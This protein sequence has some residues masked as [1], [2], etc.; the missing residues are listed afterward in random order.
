MALQHFDDRACPDPCA[1]PC[2]GCP[3]RVVCGCLKVT[4][5]TIVDAIQTL[6]LRTLTDVRRAT[7][8]GTGCTCCHKKIRSILEVHVGA[9]VALTAAG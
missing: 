6:G 8:A 1:G 2:H 4:E 7:E 5:G 3:D 9:G